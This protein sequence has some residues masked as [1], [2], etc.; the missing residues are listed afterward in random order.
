MKSFNLLGSD[1]RAGSKLRVLLLIFLIFAAPVFALGQA[2]EQPFTLAIKASK[3]MET[4]G[5]QVF[6]WVKM[7]NISDHAI[8]CTESETDGTLTSYGYDVRDEG[9]SP[10]DQRDK[11][12]R[13]SSPGHTGKRWDKCSLE[14]GKSKDIEL[15]VSLRYDL[16]KPGK[17]AIQ[18]S[19]RSLLDSKGMR[20]G[21]W[22]KSNI[23]TVTVLPAD[24]PPPAQQ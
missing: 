10:I 21:E 8:D 24:D 1:G 7:T 13:Y 12:L 3:P 16:S 18:L 17:Y 4:A 19:R 9:G 14:P 15:I 20:T 11:S 5:S 22:V 23:I 6:V 2:I